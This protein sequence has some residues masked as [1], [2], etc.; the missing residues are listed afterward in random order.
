MNFNSNW[1][2][3]ES[4]VDVWS[5]S[6]TSTNLLQIQTSHLNQNEPI[7]ALSSPTNQSDHSS[8]PT[9][10]HLNLSDTQ[11]S[12]DNNTQLTPTAEPSSSPIQPTNQLSIY[13]DAL[14]S[15][16]PIIDSELS[17]ISPSM[18]FSS[19]SE[20]STSFQ[21]VFS[22]SAINST[23]AHQDLNLTLDPPSHGFDDDDD[24]FGDFDEPS[25]RTEDDGQF[26]DFGEF[27]PLQLSLATSTSP[28]RPSRPI[29]PF[30][31]PPHINLESLRTAL[32]PALDSLFDSRLTESLEN[33]PW[34]I[35]DQV[36]STLT[37]N[38]P[39]KSGSRPAPPSIL[40]HSD[41]LQQEWNGLIEN[42]NGLGGALDWKRS[43]IRRHHLV[44]L[45]IPVDLND[46]LMP[47]P[48]SKQRLSLETRSLSQDLLHP[49]TSFPSSRLHPSLPCP[50][51]STPICTSNPSPRNG[52]LNGPI[53][54][55]D[56]QRCSELIAITED[57][58]RMI[59]VEKL[60]AIRTELTNLNS[61]VS[62]LLAQT[63]H[64]RDKLSQD[65]ESYNTM[66]SD[67]VSAAQ[68]IK[69]GS[70]NPSKRSS[71]IQLGS[72]S[73][74]SAGSGRWRTA[75]GGTHTS[76]VPSPSVSATSESSKRFSVL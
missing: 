75:F 10:T 18:V 32:A 54:S 57:E 12:F 34:L 24:D 53:V 50:P 40:S 51:T 16:L 7:Q 69:M 17:P 73:I 44:N 64:K 74:T 36:P 33:S 39:K 3:P 25:D 48:V 11:G 52:D 8:T 61:S 1:D 49:T 60:I 72:S 21:S 38:L 35:E 58:L 65:N 59:S 46:F 26:R 20:D 14:S 31:L 6:L 30:K 19:P 68:R 22:T 29:V 9:I 27:A 15:P 28:N 41:S 2:E 70:P 67:L 66:I 56:R 23:S 37:R 76:R 63:L 62:D 47:T 4:E 42:R 71:S 5:N 43:Q 55:V 13:T 45:G